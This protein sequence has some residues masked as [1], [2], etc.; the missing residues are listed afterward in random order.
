MST[1]DRIYSVI[2]QVPAGRVTTY[3]D[4]AR[5]AGL[6]GAARQVG[7][8]LAALSHESD[9]PWHRV[10]NRHGEISA[11]VASLGQQLVQADLLAREGVTLDEKGR[12]DLSARRWPSGGD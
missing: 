11:R 3:G 9:V 10:V 5:L 7:Y 8:A 12:I 1:Y 2:R 6:P 4:V